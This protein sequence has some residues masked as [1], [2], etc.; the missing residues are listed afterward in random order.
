[1]LLPVTLWLGRDFDFGAV[2]WSGWASLLY[3]AGL[4]SVL[5]YLIYYYALQRISASRVSTFSY[6]QP[7]LATLM[8][9]PMLG[10]YPTRAIVIGG[11]LVFAGVFLAE[12][13]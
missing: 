1:M 12:R 4:S 3:M 5:C 11:L 10:E 8:A 7:L 2:T 9:I 6:L 13:A